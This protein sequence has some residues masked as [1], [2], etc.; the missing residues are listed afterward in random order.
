MDREY[1]IINNDIH[2]ENLQ[3]KKEL[4][5]F[6]EKKVQLNTENR[7][8]IPPKIESIRNSV[9]RVTNFHQQTKTDKRYLAKVGNG[10]FA[11]QATQKPNFN[12]LRSINP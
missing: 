6:K 7:Y 5:F 8:F 3:K 2:E 9:E 12:Q 10:N 4:T 1:N 11:G